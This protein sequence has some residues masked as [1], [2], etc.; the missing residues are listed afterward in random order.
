MR[1]TMQR[2]VMFPS[3]RAYADVNAAHYGVCTLQSVPIYLQQLPSGA[4]L[5][6]FRVT[7]RDQR[8][9]SCVREEQKDRS[10]TRGHSTR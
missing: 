9:M 6:N 7:V 5:E 4:S 10:R 3:P 2:K 8:N 1:K